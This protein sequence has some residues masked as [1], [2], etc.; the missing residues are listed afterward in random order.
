VIVV[1]ETKGVSLLM[2]VT[3]ALGVAFWLVLGVMLQNWPI[4]LANA[5]TFVLT[6]IIIAMKLHY[7]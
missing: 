3:F 7:R 4:I 2:H 5:V 1:R 6:G